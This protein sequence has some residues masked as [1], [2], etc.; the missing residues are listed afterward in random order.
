MRWIPVESAVGPQVRVHSFVLQ[1]QLHTS[2]K[3]AAP[4]MAPANMDARMIVNLFFMLVD[5][6]G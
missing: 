4:M 2:Q 3:I 5:F 1:Q 6:Q